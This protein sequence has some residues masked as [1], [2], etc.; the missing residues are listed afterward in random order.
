MRMGR[1]EFLKTSAALAAASAAN[2]SCIEIASAA[3][4]E[5]LTVDKLAIRVLVDSSYD[6]FFRPAEANGVKI[7]PPPRLPDYRR[8]LHNEWG[9]S[10]WLESERGSEKR[11]V[12]LDYGYTPAVLLRRLQRCWLKA[13]PS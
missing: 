7:S 2:L 6:L 4:I 12:M 8:S 13:P 5:V 9:L 1:R 10:L 3:P 11:T